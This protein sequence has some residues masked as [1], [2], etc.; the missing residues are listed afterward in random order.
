MVI[1]RA[2]HAS[3]TCPF[4][5]AAAVVLAAEVVGQQGLEVAVAVADALAA[6]AEDTG[7]LTVVR[8][9]HEQG[10]GSGRFQDTAVALAVAAAVDDDTGLRHLSAVVLSEHACAQGDAVACAKACQARQPG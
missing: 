9:L 6:V 3:D 4:R 2:V 1:G 10:T 8:L 5:G 7:H